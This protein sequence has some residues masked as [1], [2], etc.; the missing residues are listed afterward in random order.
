M[1]IE[2]DVTVR[3]HVEAAIL[4]CSRVS[5]ILFTNYMSGIIDWVEETVSRVE[6]LFFVHN[7]ESVAK[8]RDMNHVVRTLKTCARAR[9]HWVESR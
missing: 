1:I 2:A 3:A 7:V 6:C 4:W 5:P 9:I 8:G